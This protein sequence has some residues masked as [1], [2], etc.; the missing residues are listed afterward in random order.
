MI[1]EKPIQERTDEFSLVYPNYANKARG[2][3]VVLATILMWGCAASDM[4]S[5]PHASVAQSD[6]SQGTASTTT[7]DLREVTSNENHAEAFEVV[8]CLLPGQVRRL[9]VQMIYMTPRRPVRATAE[10]CVI[11]GGEYVSYDRAD[12]GT[13]LEIWKKA[14]DLGNVEAQYYVATLYERGSRA[15]LTMSLPSN[16]TKKQQNRGIAKLL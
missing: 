8:D 1:L 15:H 2:F 14:A 4:Q 7:S 16:G 5:A 9:G 11:R 3:V 10:D 12:Y 6:S 13:A